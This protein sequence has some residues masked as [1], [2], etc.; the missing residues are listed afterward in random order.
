M[1]KGFFNNNFCEKREDLEVIVIQ[2]LTKRICSLDSCRNLMN[3]KGP[4]KNALICLQME[5]Y[6]IKQNNFVEC[7]REESQMSC[8]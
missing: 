2:G 1:K 7:W 4:Y 8:S 3:K 6:T 5:C